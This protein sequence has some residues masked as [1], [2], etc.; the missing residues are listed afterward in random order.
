ME[1][2]VE[3]GLTILEGGHNS[4]SPFGFDGVTCAFDKGLNDS[5]LSLLSWT[6]TRR[7]DTQLDLTRLSLGS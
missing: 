3:G 2:P 4:K 5:L 6:L 1:H 7:L